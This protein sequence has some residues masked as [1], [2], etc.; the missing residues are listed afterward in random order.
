MGIFSNGKCVSK[1]ELTGKVVVITGANS[2]IGYE[3]TKDLLTRGIQSKLVKS[4]VFFN[5]NYIQVPE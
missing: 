3:T 1:A 4:S 5:F 2:G